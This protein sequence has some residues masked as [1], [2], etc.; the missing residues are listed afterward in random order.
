MKELL[1]RVF[2]EGEHE[3]TLSE[4]ASVTWRTVR[5]DFDLLIYDLGE[6]TPHE[7]QDF[8]HWR[9]IT[10]LPMIAVGSLA[11]EEH[12]VRA[13]RM[14]ADDYVARPLH[15]AE[16][17]ARCEALFRRERMSGSLE[18]PKAQTSSELDLDWRPHQVRINGRR[19]DLTPIEFKLLE[20]LWQH[21]G[22]PVSRDELA[23]QVWSKNQTAVNT[24]LSLYIWHLRQKLEEDPRHPKLIL[25]RWRM[26]YSFQ[27]AEDAEGRPV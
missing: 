14:G 7:W 1:L 9:Q 22:Q 23:R 27:E 25:T 2:Q 21:R 6:A 16:L 4:S 18:S 11:Q 20:I 15:V 10:D 19:I 13:L 8:A 3:V 17:V 5:G 26:G 12:A 24:N